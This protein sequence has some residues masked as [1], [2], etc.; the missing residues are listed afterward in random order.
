M[1]KV[2]ARVQ[3]VDLRPRCG[4]VTSLREMSIEV[5]MSGLRVGQTCAIN[6]HSRDGSPLLADVVTLTPAG[7]ILI[8]YGDIRGISA[9]ALVYDYAHEPEVLVGDHLLGAVLDGLG[10]PM[11]EFASAPRELGNPPS[12]I[13]LR[14]ATL[15]PMKRPLIDTPLELGVV[16]IDA[17]NT[18]GKGQRMGVFG[19]PGTGKSTLMAALARNSSA[20]VVVVGLVGE[21]GREVREFIERELPET[22]RNNVVVVAATSDRASIERLRAAHTATAI[23]EGFRDRGKDVLL[24]LDSLTRVAR[25]LREIGLAAGEAPTRRGFPASVYPALPKLIE[26]SG[27]APQGSITAFYTVLLE[28]DGEGDPIAEEVRS[29]TDGHL[30]LSRTLAEAGHYPAIDI[31]QSLS[32]LMTFVADERTVETARDARAVL[33]KYDDVKLL[34]ELGELQTGMDPAADR[35]IER[36]P[37]LA[38]A[39]VQDLRRPGPT[40]AEACALVLAALE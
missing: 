19:P 25:A 11:V 23:A 34:V 28:G 27:T 18:V 2:L 36:M 24:I 14:G 38:N 32:R 26:R 40:L 31:R 4:E 35:A 15:D 10:Q 20:D 33:A 5:S 21:R 9:G 30:T 37:K 16:G 12:R 7:G 3:R 22:A 29:L 13:P 1:T 6:A 17:L 8:P 39:L